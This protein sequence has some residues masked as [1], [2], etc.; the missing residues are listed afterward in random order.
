MARQFKNSIA[1]RN[2]LMLLFMLFEN[3]SLEST[4]KLRIFRL[5]FSIP[6]AM[7]SVFPPRWYWNSNRVM[8]MEYRSRTQWN[9]VYQGRYLTNQPELLLK[10]YKRDFKLSHSQFM[11]LLEM[12]TFYS[13]K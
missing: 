9:K 2:L 12:I 7:T 11:Q 3:S 6:L 8:W 4:Y 13:K 5:I 1:H 10:R